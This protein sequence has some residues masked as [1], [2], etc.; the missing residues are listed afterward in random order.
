MKYFYSNLCFVSAIALLQNQEV[1]AFII[2][3]SNS[4]PN[5]FGLALKVYAPPGGPAQPGDLVRHFLIEPTSKGVRLKGCADEPVFSSLSALV[6]QHSVTP[7]ALPA[8]L[9]LPGSDPAPP[10]PEGAARELLAAG[11]ACSVLYIG[12]L[13]CEALTG[14]EAIAR[15][16]S[17][18]FPQRPE[19]K[20]A[21]VHFK[22]TAQGITLTDS[23]RRLFF[24]RHYPKTS[25]SYCGLDPGD[26]RW[27]HTTDANGIP[28]SK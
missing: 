18:L 15:T 5:A 23:A 20:P 14:P 13:G 24:R 17:K 22:V 27:S 26:K 6:Y 10:I 4:F 8:K 25:V 11:A 12:G 2:R 1:G 7:L 28:S 21:M 19:L 16:V 9:K 3:D